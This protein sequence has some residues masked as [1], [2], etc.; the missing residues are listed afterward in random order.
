MNS[1]QQKE[2]VNELLENKKKYLYKKD[3][4]DK[5]L[6]D[7]NPNKDDLRYIITHLVLDENIFFWMDFISEN[8]DKIACDKQNFINIIK[9]L[10]IKIKSDMA[11]GKFVNALISIGSKNPDLGFKIYNKLV[12]RP[13]DTSVYHYACLLLGGIGRSKFNEVKNYIQLRLS[14]ELSDNQFV[15]AGFITACRVI[16]ESDQEFKNKSFYYKIVDFA[17]KPNNSE[18]I[19]IQGALLAF[20]I[21]KFDRE[22]SLE[23]IRKFITDKPSENLLSAISERIWVWGLDNKS[24]DFEIIELIV[25]YDNDRV[26]SHICYFLA[27]NNSYSKSKSFDILIRMLESDKST[28]NADFHYAIEEMG[29]T[30]FNFYKKK[31]IEYVNKCDK[32]NVLFD[33]SYLLHDFTKNLEASEEEVKKLIKIINS[34]TKLLYEKYDREKL[35]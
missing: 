33:L 24:D 1:E 16:I 7:K 8:L 23:F 21:N 35:V 9:N 19:R 27:K 13:K 22:K 6:S 12:D 26:Y 11:Q 28:A 32:S 3:A 34:R 15:K 4:I 30:D 17:N 10:I 2:I 18:I 5:L 29:K 14:T 25:K 20:D 31:M